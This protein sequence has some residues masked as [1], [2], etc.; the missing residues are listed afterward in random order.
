M[1]SIVRF[2]ATESDPKISSHHPL[3]LAFVLHVEPTLVTQRPQNP[4]TDPLCFILHLGVV[5]GTFLYPLA[6]HHA[7][8]GWHQVGAALPGTHFP[9]PNLSPTPCLGT[10]STVLVPLLFQ[11]AELSYCF[12]H[13]Y[14]TGTRCDIRSQ[15]FSCPGAEGQWLLLGLGNSGR[16]SKSPGAA[17]YDGL[18][19]SLWA[20]DGH[21]DF[22]IIWEENLLVVSLKR[23]LVAI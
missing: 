17:T 18:S 13:C 5:S 19:Q 15:A 4:T 3:L 20:N 1:K 12:F 8:S 2:S 16:V 14:H 6:G 10:L 7:F 22:W 23:C 11:V 9:L 21:Y